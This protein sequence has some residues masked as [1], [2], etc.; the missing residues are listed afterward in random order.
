MH[1]RFA[2][3]RREVEEWWEE[4]RA[5]LRESGE[6]AR[7]GGDGAALEEGMAQRV[8]VCCI[9]ER[10][11][12]RKLLEDTEEERTAGVWILSEESVVAQ[13]VQQ[14]AQQKVTQVVLNLHQGC[15]AAAIAYAATREEA[16]TRGEEFPYK[17]V[18]AFAL[19][20]ARAL[21]RQLQE[22][23]IT[24]SIQLQTFA[25]CISDIEGECDAVERS[26]YAAIDLPLSEGG[27]EHEAVGVLIIGRREYSQFLQANRQFPRGL[28]VV[29]VEDE[30]EMRRQ[31]AIAVSI[32][33]G[34]HNIFAYL[35][36]RACPFTIYV[37]KRLSAPLKR[38]REW[39]EKVAVATLE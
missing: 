21:A 1:E 11:G 12:G 35:F 31:L 5:L 38:A 10:V 19:A 8:Y 37:A 24:A 7:A 17:N 16:Q 26:M 30:E 13:W 6:A 33:L 9:D 29:T 20:R 22:A 3:Y 34:S 27:A 15:G 28:F 23:G 18:E 39:G 2:A 14:L 4:A 36:S 25:D 32:G